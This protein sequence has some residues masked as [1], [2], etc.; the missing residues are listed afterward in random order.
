LI[1]LL[2]DDHELGLK[3]LSMLATIL[4]TMWDRKAE[5]GIS[6]VGSPDSTPGQNLE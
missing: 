6:S 5:A 2:E 1:D 4:V 3:F